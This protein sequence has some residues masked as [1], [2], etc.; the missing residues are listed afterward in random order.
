LDIEEGE[1]KTS[2]SDGENTQNR[3][4]IKN[5]QQTFLGNIPTRKSNNKKSILNLQ[6]LNKTPKGHLKP[7]MNNSASSSKLQERN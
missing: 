1:E 6:N 5:S 4:T 3:K 7:I 2:Q